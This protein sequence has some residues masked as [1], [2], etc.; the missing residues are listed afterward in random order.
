MT[1]SQKRMKSI[2]ERLDELRVQ[3]SAGEIT[4]VRCGYK[5]IELLQDGL[6]SLG[7]FFN[8]PASVRYLATGE[9]TFFGNRDRQEEDGCAAFG[10][11]L[12]VWLN[13]IPTRTGT[14]PSQGHVLAVNGWTHINHFDAEKLLRKVVKYYDSSGWR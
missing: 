10:E 3:L 11:A 14:Q 4:P 6:E 5:R 1:A 8:F 9:F 13:T 7:N 12:A 2:I